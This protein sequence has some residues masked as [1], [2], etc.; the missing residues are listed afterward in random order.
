MAMLYGMKSAIAFNKLLVKCGLLQDT[1]KG[2][3]LAER[4]R[5][6]GLTAVIDS[7]FRLPNGVNA[8]YKKAVWTARGQEY[9]R[10]CLG[11]FGIWPV[12]EQRDLFGAM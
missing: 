6:L 10:R 7:P 11:H 4:L 9:V 1:S 12:G 3:V 8:I 2:Y 5:N